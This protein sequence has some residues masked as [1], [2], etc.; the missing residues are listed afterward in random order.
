MTYHYALRL[1][2]YPNNETKVNLCRVLVPEFMNAIGASDFIL[3]KEYEKN[4]HFHIVF[5]YNGDEFF[6]QKKGDTKTAE[7]KE[8]LYTTFEVPDDKKGNPTYS[9]EPVR[10]LDEALSYAVKCGDYDYSSEWEDVA[11]EAYQNSY[12]KKHS[13]KSSLA[14]LTDKYIKGDIN[15]RDLWIG[16]GQ[17]RAE[18]GIPLSLRWV[19]EM[20]LSIQ[21]K[22]DPTKL[23][24]LWEFRLI[25]Q[26]N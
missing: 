24:D 2:P 22:K 15:D 3:G 11:R 10:S 19:D 17:T 20:T 5:S 16:L 18:L 26:N 23:R 8:L 12:E 21:C 25:K 14:D 13:L 6:P 4:H 9:L 7:I 1:T